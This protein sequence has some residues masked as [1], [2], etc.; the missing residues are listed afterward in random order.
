[1]N[2]D[3]I[4]V[5]LAALETSL[6]ERG[7]TALALFGSTA[8]GTYRPDSDVDVLVDVDPDFKFSLVDLVS[9]KH[10][11]EDAL[12]CEVDVVIRE[13]LNPAIRD[14]VIGEARAVF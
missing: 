7:V 1:M 2:R 5:R 9:V 6:R 11:L 4:H 14:Q 8:R 3:K 13:G 12:E 10:F